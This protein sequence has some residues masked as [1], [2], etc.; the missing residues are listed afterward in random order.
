VDYNYKSTKGAM[1]LAK[2]FS[3]SLTCAQSRIR[4]IFKGESPRYFEE[5]QKQNLNSVTFAAAEKVA[6]LAKEKNAER[7]VM[8]DVDGLCSYTEAIIVC[9]GRS[10]R[11]VQA[12][13]DHIAKSMK[14]EGSG[15][16]GIEGMEHGQWVL[17]DL[18][19]VVV[20]VFYEPVREYYNIEHIWPEAKITVFD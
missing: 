12:I 19:D 15:T 16:I 3:L 8:I 7:V 10:T 6:M 11:Q 13:A 18:N 2:I 1:N 20:H 4:L 14:Q 9:A 17:V 5:A